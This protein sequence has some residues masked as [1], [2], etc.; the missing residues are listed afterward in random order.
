[1]PYVHLALIRMK[2][3]SGSII[4]TWDATMAAKPVR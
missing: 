3:Q 4:E 2:E 1:M